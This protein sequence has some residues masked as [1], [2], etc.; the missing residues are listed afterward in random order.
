MLRFIC[1]LLGKQYEPCKSCEVLRNQLEIENHKNELLQS[2]LLDLVKP[3]VFESSSIPVEPIKPKVVPW[4]IKK[5][6][7]EDQ[8]RIEAKLQK[9]YTE[10]LEKELEISNADKVEETM[11]IDANGKT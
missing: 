2:T 5:R 4:H 8:S 11:G 7:L 1:F 10:R 6:E 3:K 9:E